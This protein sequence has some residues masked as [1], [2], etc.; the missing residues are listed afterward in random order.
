[1][2]A[3]KKILM[4]L[5][6]GFS[7]LGHAWADPLAGKDPYALDWTGQQSDANSLAY[8]QAF[9]APAGSV[10]ESI[11]WWGFHT[12]DSGGAS[13]DNFLVTLDGV[14]QAGTLVSSQF[15]EFFS[16]YTLTLTDADSLLTSSVLGVV[17]DSADVV[18]WWQSAQAQGNPQ[19]PDATA[20]AFRL[21]GH[22]NPQPQDV[23]EPASLALFLLALGALALRQAKSGK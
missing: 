21:N 16:E 6:L 10:L 15:N 1:M 5:I 8:S 20:V 9:A 11:T 2:N 19:G 14:V 17:N 13:F 4:G 7:L 23:P 3:M 18:W 12:L 22:S